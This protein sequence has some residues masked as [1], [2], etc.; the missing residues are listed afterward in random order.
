MTITKL[1]PLRST[2]SLIALLLFSIP[3]LSQC[4]KSHLLIVD[5]L[6]Q[7]INTPEDAW[8]YVFNDGRDTLFLE[9]LYDLQFTQS[10]H[11]F[12]FSRIPDLKT[13][14]DTISVQSSTTFID[15]TKYCTSCMA[16]TTLLLDSLDLNQDGVNELFLQRT[17]YCFVSPSNMG[18]HGTGCQQ[19]QYS[20]YEVWDP[21]SKNLLFE[22]KNQ[23]ESQIA[24]SVSVVRS[25][26]YAFKVLVDDTGNF[27]L[28]ELKVSYWN[29]LEMG[30]YRF[31]LACECY[32][33]D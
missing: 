29:A 15:S 10:M 1:S 5:S 18:A 32:V 2:Y 33:K 31:N 14:G 17:W 26:G 12:R 23:A 20:T 19:Q 28:S 16:E 24:A 25:D 8:T 22:V 7:E 13:W 4:E 3:V 9:P 11:G 21:K 27:H 30:T 6:A